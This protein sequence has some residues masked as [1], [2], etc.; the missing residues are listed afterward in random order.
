MTDAVCAMTRRSLL[1]SKLRSR[2]F[3]VIVTA[4]VPHLSVHQ[5]RESVDY[6]KCVFRR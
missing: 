2:K 4:C 5:R 6:F 1:N 3:Q